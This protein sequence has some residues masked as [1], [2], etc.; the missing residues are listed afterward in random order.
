MPSDPAIKAGTVADFEGSMAA[1]M[2][3]ALAEEYEKLKD[4]PLP[5]TGEDDR[6]LLFAAIAQGIVRHLKDN[7][8]AF[9]VTVEVDQVTGESGAPLIASKNLNAIPVGMSGSIATEAVEVTQNDAS[10]NLV[11]SRGSGTGNELETTGT[12]Y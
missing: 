9:K 11:K 3:N 12:L 7:I 6:K 4:Q 10:N 2:E 8:G 5:E 1:A